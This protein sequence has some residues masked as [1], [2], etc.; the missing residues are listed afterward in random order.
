MRF[1]VSRTASYGDIPYE[2]AEPIAVPDLDIDR[3]TFQS[4][5]EHDARLGEPWAKR[6]VVKGK[7]TAGEES[8]IYRLVRRVPDPEWCVDLPDISALLAFLEEF[9]QCVICGGD[10]SVYDP[11]LPADVEEF[12]RLPTIEIYDGYGE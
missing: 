10:G 5:Q 2:N 4:E 3:R 7:W 1:I 6:A 12:T 9:G 11:P 8:G